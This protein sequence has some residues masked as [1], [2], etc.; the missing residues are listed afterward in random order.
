MLSH[1]EMIAVKVALHERVLL[2]LLEVRFADDA[3]PIASATAYAEIRVPRP[4]E[5]IDEIEERAAI[6]GEAVRAQ[7]FDRLISNLRARLGPNAR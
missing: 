1:D 2:D 7:F 4:S 6:A 3:T 5:P